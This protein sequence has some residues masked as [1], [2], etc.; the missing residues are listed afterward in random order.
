MRVRVCVC[1]SAGLRAMAR[2]AG[3]ARLVRECGSHRLP[4]TVQHRRAGKAGARH[5]QI[6]VCLHR[7]VRACCAQDRASMRA[8]AGSMLS[9]Q[10]SRARCM[11]PSCDARH[12]LLPSASKQTLLWTRTRAR[13]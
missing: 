12:R 5:A 6:R 13:T 3:R 11:R 2:R 10:R 7:C 1:A 4:Q 9:P 8:C